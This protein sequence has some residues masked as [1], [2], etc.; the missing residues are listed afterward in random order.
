MFIELPIIWKRDDG[1]DI[2]YEL[3]GIE[4]DKDDI[5]TLPTLINIDRCTVINKSTSDNKCTLRF[6]NWTACIDM[7][8]D[9]LKLL[10]ES[11]GLLQ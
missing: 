2:D 11:K 3:M 7:P 8:Y 4:Q 10:L 5:K 1:D 6:K 9:D